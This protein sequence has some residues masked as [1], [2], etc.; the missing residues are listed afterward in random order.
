MYG[1]PRAEMLVAPCMP[2]VSGVPCVASFPG[3]HVVCGVFGVPA[4]L[5]PPHTSF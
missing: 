3:V 1:V 2:G 5:G 4:V